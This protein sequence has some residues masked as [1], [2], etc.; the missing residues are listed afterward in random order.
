MKLNYSS[1]YCKFLKE[2]NPLLSFFKN[3][4]SMT[5]LIKVDEKDEN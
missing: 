3:K 1:D 2:K 4:V 5:T